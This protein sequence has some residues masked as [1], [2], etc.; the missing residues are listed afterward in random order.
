[1]IND[2][3]MTHIRCI[4]MLNTRCVIDSATGGG[5]REELEDRHDSRGG[6]AAGVGEN[7]VAGEG[8]AEREPRH[9]VFSL[10]RL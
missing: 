2:A 5:G 10:Q 8:Q 7:C 4:S 9:G 6:G 3:F 1:M